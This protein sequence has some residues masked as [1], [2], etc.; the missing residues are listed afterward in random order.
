[1]TNHVSYGQFGLAE[2][3]HER[4]SWSFPRTGAHPLISEL[5]KDGKELLK[6]SIKD[7]PAQPCKSPTAIVKRFPEL[8][9]ASSQLLQDLAAE[10]IAAE[11]SKTAPNERG[12]L[13]A[14]GRIAYAKAELGSKIS[15][16]VAPVVAIPSGDSGS[17]VRVIRL[18]QRRR[19]FNDSPGTHVELPFLSEEAGYWVGGTEPLLQLVFADTA[20]HQGSLLAA[21]LRSRTLIFRPLW[22]QTR[23]PP[24]GAYVGCPYPP[25]YIEVNPL[26]IVS[27]GQTGGVPHADVCFDLQDQRRFA[28]VDVSGN[29]NVFRIAGRHSRSHMMYHATI[30]ASS[31]ALPS[32]L[33]AED[34]W[35]EA[36]IGLNGDYANPSSTGDRQQSSILQNS[37][38]RCLFHGSGLIIFSRNKIFFAKLVGSP[39][40]VE[41]PLSDLHTG[42][43]EILDVRSLPD[44]KDNICVLTSRRVLYLSLTQD[45]VKL[46]PNIVLS[47]PHYRNQDDKELR[48]SSLLTSRLELVLLVY[49][50]QATLCTVFYTQLRAST[51]KI[52]VMD[53][54]QFS[55]PL[56]TSLVYMQQ[57]QVKSPGSV[58]K[59]EPLTSLMLLSED[60][61]LAIKYYMLV[62]DTTSSSA[63]LIRLVKPKGK[64]LRSFLSDALILRED[65]A[66]MDGIEATST[67]GNS[68]SLAT[69]SWKSVWH[70]RRTV[71]QFAVANTINHQATYSRLIQ[72]F[73]N[74]SGFS[75]AHTSDQ[76]HLQERL[77]RVIDNFNED[78]VSTQGTLY[79]YPYHVAN[80]QS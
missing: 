49:S 3:N 78:D 37:Y 41:L 67:S 27:T 50:S 64:Q 55:I 46:I 60:L 69:P 29:W 8:Q 38:F 47:W 2:Y 23:K 63:S 71:P 80:E 15:G 25:S 17:V 48:L 7:V 68:S 32:E 77:L 65:F 19:N 51:K 42:W 72:K 53:P 24:V 28:I 45:G 79:V 74:S 57:H 6:A 5:S 44:H 43:A 22:H 12:D 54:L 35:T 30:V 76:N 62:P 56:R 73:E 34:S 40:S 4:E 16:H 26:L 70:P 59:P 11:K 9:P 58:T 61:L 14:F 66:V 36:T 75:V 10:S 18:E 31:N 33:Q 39:F 52:I 20:Q 21:R 1:M 13:L